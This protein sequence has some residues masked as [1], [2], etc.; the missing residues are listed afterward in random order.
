ML[1]RFT[2]PITTSLLALATAPA[3]AQDEVTGSVGSDT[4]VNQT[5]IQAEIV[6][7]AGW[8]TEQPY[9]GGWSVDDLI[10]ADVYT[11]ASAMDQGDVKN[12]LFDTD[13]NILSIVAEVG[14]LFELGDVHVNIPWDQVDYDPDEDRVIV[15][16]TVENV[17]DYGLYSDEVVTSFAAAGDIMEVSGDGAGEVGT[18]PRVFRATDLLQDY[19]RIQDQGNWS[20]YGFID[21]VIVRDGSI[22]A[23][24]VQ[25][26]VGW[27][28]PNAYAYPYYGYG[29]GWTPGSPYYDLPYQ[30]GDIEGLQPMESAAVTGNS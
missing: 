7:L 6:P 15:P 19:V 26:D 24:V 1:K 29:S 14:G 11:P 20:N 4:A 18:G 10:G 16:V 28:R 30:R 22:A 23:V 13:G 27:G 12:V 8:Q 2:L 17:G 5:T 3:L 25:P 21:D 9:Q